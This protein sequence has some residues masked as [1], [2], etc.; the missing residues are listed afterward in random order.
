MKTGHISRNSPT[1]SK[2]PSNEFNKGKRKVDVENV[3][4]EMNKMWKRKEDCS[5]SS[6]DKITSP[7]GLGDHTSLN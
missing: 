2:A 3:R 6:V 7:N 1:R 4:D 5:T